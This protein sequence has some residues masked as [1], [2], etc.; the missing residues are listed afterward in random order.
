MFH[1]ID[2][3]GFGKAHTRLYECPAAENVYQSENHAGGSKQLPAEE[4]WSPAKKSNLVRKALVREMTK[5][6]V[7]TLAELQR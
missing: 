6:L 4:V 5:N 1:L 7:V 2:W 3:T